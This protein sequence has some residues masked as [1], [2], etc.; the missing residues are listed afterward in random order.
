MTMARNT[1]ASAPLAN[2]EL[3]VIKAL[4]VTQASPGTQER[5]VSV[6]VQVVQ[7]AEEKAGSTV[8]W[9]NPVD[10]ASPESTVIKDARERKEAAESQD[11]P[12]SK[13][14]K[15]AQAPMAKRAMLEK[16]ENADLTGNKAPGA[17]LVNEVPKEKMVLTARPEPV[18]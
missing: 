5:V 15:V 6:V 3:Q 17:S 7:D 2:L 10:E 12:E 14:R 18:E 13:E 8:R 9:E 16:P 1:A 4:V 11:F